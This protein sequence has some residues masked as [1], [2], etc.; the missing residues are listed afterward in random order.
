MSPSSRRRSHSRSKVHIPD[1]L[2]AFLGIAL[3]GIVL[4]HAGCVLFRPLCWTAGEELPNNQRGIS[5]EEE[6]LEA[7]RQK[8]DLQWFVVWYP[9]PAGLREAEAVLKEKVVKLHFGDKTYEPRITRL[10]EGTGLSGT[11]TLIAIFL[12][13]REIP[14][15][16]DRQF[17][18]SDQRVLLRRQWRSYLN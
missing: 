18:Y 8:K 7:E 9:T 5:V 17:Q 4:Y 16:A 1:W 14:T 10:T 11:V 2:G 12:V 3:V 6:K 15:D 13:P